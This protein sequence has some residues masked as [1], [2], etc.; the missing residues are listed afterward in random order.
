[1]AGVL[2]IH[3]LRIFLGALYRQRLAG[4]LAATMAEGAV[5]KWKAVSAHCANAIE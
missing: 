2:A 3:K 5:H 4:P 1:M